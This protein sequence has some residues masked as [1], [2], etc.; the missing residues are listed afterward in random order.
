MSELHVNAVPLD[1]CMLLALEG[2]IDLATMHILEDALEREIRGDEHEVVLDLARVSFLSVGGV[3]ALVRVLTP[4]R[5]RGAAVVV[6]SA[7][8]PIRQT[9]AA[10]E[11]RGLFDLDGDDGLV[12]GERA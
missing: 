8:N 11:T 12:E 1:R 5:A 3:G 2:E 10:L 7:S 6:R 4:L 9:L